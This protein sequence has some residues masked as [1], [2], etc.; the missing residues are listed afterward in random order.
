MTSGMQIVI[1]GERAEFGLTERRQS[2]TDLAVGYTAV[3]VL[4]TDV[5]VRAMPHRYCG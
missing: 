1:T 3:P 4:K 5:V 2:R